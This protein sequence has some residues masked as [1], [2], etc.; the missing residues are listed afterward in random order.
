M[1]V[2]ERFFSVGTGDER[3]SFLYQRHTP[4]TAPQ[5]DL[6]DE[7]R[8]RENTPSRRAQWLANLSL[9]RLMSR[10]FSVGS[11]ADTAMGRTPLS[12]A[13]K[14][15]RW[16][17]L[18]FLLFSLLLLF[19]YYTRWSPLARMHTQEENATAPPLFQISDGQNWFSSHLPSF[20]A[21]AEEAKHIAFPSHAFDF[22]DQEL[23]PGL[24]SRYKTIEQ[25]NNEAPQCRLVTKAEL[26]YGRVV[27]FANATTAACYPL[28][29]L[30]T[31]L[32]RFLDTD[33][34]KT[35]LFCQFACLTMFLNE[36]G[37]ELPCMCAFRLE[38]EDL[39]P[40]VAVN[41]ALR[42]ALTEE[43]EEAAGAVFVKERVAY[44]RDLWETTQ[45]RK[46]AVPQL[47]RGTTLQGEEIQQWLRER[48]H[49]HLITHMLFVM[50]GHYDP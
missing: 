27:L 35:A 34:C 30:A 17:L 19:F 42:E 22:P 20:F 10:L 37:W 47:L 18:L 24:L 21:H 39:S 38:R 50:R 16:G 31:H 33:H 12:L 43:K 15:R 14:R 7:A 41:L 8:R 44:I 25:F 40:V 36:T 1:E 13:Q 45:T 2:E 32:L 26:E 9:Q 11:G 29:T 3:Q 5:R 23:P 4:A 28:Q 49:T 48:A 6:F 46:M